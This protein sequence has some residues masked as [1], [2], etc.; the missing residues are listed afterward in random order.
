MRAWMVSAGVMCCAI[1]GAA[2]ITSAADEVDFDRDIAPLL[3]ARC[4][5][6]HGG[7]D[8]KAGLDLTRRELVADKEGLLVPG[9][10]EESDLWLRVESDEMPPKKPLDPAEKELLKRWI[11]GGGKWGTSPIDPFRVTTKFRAGYD[12]WSLQPVLRS[13][14]PE[15]TGHEHPVDRFV[16]QRLKDV[17]RGALRDRPAGGS[18]PQATLSPE[19]TRRVLMRRVTYDLI[20]LPPRRKSRSSWPIRGRTPTSAWSTVCWLALTMESGRR[21]SGWMSCGLGKAMASSATRSAP[22][23]GPIATG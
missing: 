21:D 23:P 2:E 4:L 10:P 22:A 13:S 20:G 12:W 5:D 9:S 8:P 19:A 3:V 18:E 14:L 11:A 17:A 15:G 1:V 6:C 7:T 16:L